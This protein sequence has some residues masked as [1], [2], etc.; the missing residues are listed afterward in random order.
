[1]YLNAREHG[2]PDSFAARAHV[3]TSTYR[4][5]TGCMFYVN[6]ARGVKAR[7]TAS[8]ESSIDG[9]SGAGVKDDS[10]GRF[11]NRVTPKVFRFSR[12]EVRTLEETRVRRRWLWSIVAA[13]S[14]TTL[15]RSFLL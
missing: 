11:V 2:N 12:L 6:V 13:E 15:T 8:S 4:W 3:C 5:N 10:S 1:M 9:R 7:G 14:V